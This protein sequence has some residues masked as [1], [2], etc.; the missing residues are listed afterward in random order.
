MDVHR[1]I[2]PQLVLENEEHIAHAP[3]V[4]L[5]GNVP[6]ETIS[7]VLRLCGQRRIPAHYKFS[8]TGG[9]MLR[10]NHVHT[11]DAG[12]FEGV[13]GTFCDEAVDDVVRTSEDG[14]GLLHSGTG[15]TGVCSGVADLS[16]SGV[17][18]LKSPTLDA[19]GFEGV[20]GTFC[21]EAVDDVVRTSE[22][23]GG[24]LHSGTGRT[25]VCSGVADLSGSGVMLLK[26]PTTDG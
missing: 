2:S 3:V 13:A 1:H 12:G 22:D 17:M 6:V 10:P 23:G 8:R 4:V 16:G 7:C 20:A 18:L 14:G 5:D 11:L 24:L 25:G 9:L 15:R 21:D 26:S 19:G